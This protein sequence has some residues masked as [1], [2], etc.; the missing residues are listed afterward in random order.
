MKG[1]VF[2]RLG[3]IGRC[4]FNLLLVKEITYSQAEKILNVCKLG[5]VKGANAANMRMSINKAF[6]E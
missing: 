2:A 6:G 1:G 5:D 3:I 4:L